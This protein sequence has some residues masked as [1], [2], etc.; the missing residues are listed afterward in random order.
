[1][2][3]GGIYGAL[4][5]WEAD[6]ITNEGLWRYHH[7]AARPSQAR[8]EGERDERLRREPERVLKANC[9][10]KRCGCES[11]RAENPSVLGR[12]GKWEA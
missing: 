1:M 3:V 5:K 2:A 10:C 11:G 8:L 7:A 9:A 6:R 4:P 12:F